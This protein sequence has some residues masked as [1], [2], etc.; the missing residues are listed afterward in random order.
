[1]TA[2]LVVEQAITDP[3]EF[4][5]YHELVP[6]TVATYDGRYL[7]R[8]GAM[9]RSKGDYHPERVTIIAGIE[10]AAF[11]SRH[12]PR[13]CMALRATAQPYALLV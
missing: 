7:V 1:M 5:R 4:A 10:R 11:H 6:P 12:V 13:Q 2:C 8:D 3:V 9:S